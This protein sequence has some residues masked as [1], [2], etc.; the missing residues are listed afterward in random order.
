MR[1]DCKTAQSVEG[2]AVAS[3]TLR[4]MRDAARAGAPIPAHLVG[5]WFRALRDQLFADHRPVRLEQNDPG[6]PYWIQIDERQWHHALR[7]RINVRALYVHPLPGERGRRSHKW[8]P[9]RTH[10][11]ACSDSFEWAE[12]YCDPP[13]PPEPMST[14]PQPFNPRWVLPILDRL[15]LAMRRESKRER[16]KWDREAKLIRRSIEEN[17]KEAQT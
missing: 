8:S 17:T 13:R 14:K 12:A 7:R 3:D 2:L 15:E 5:E 11:T 16:E 9:D 6:S 1:K 4:T 10:C